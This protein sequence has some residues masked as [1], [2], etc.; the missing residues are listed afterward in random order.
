MKLFRGET[1]L[2]CSMREPIS[3]SAKESRRTPGFWRLL[4]AWLFLFGVFQAH[5]SWPAPEPNEPHYL[6]KAKRFWDRS[7]IED[8]AFLNSRDAHGV[9]FFTC[10]WITQFLSLPAAAWTGRIVCNS[11]LALGW[12]R[13]GRSLELS[14]L[15]TVFSGGAWIALNE[16][17]QMAGEWIVGGFEAK[18]IAYGLMLLGLAQAA[19]GNWR[20]CWPWLG[21]S[22]AF[23]PLVG[24]WSVVACLFAWALV[25]R[26]EQTLVSQLSRLFLGGAASLPGVLPILLLNRGV[27]HDIRELAARVYF[28]RLRHH[29]DI[30]SFPSNMV[31]AMCL[32]LVVWLTLCA[33]SR[34]LNRND[35]QRQRRLQAAVAGSLLIA[36]FGILFTLPSWEQPSRAAWILRYYFYRTA[37][38]YVPLGTAIA[39]AVGMMRTPHCGENK[40]WNYG[41]TALMLVLLTWHMT[42]LRE[43]LIAKI[44]RADKPGKIANFADWVDVC[45]WI[46]LNTD[47]RDRFLTPRLGQSFKWRAER[48]EVVTAKD[49]P[50]DDA[51]LALWHTLQ[52]EVFRNMD[53]CAEANWYQVVGE[54]EGP[55]AVQ[56]AHRTKATHIVTERRYPMNWQPIYQNKSYAV[57]KVP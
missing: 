28:R 44:P 43:R 18:G 5:G 3:D 2:M 29:L 35:W 56:I 11:L 9:F 8:D 37:D 36:V 14:L 50:Q 42:T 16:H 23:H 27:D 7:W 13:L 4:V 19:Q 24:G 20:G 40:R 12:L 52:Q 17:G 30:T 49:V 41:I 39:A 38:V 21:V 33:L 25:G 51:G 55:V 57:Y 54:Y 47:R 26:R 22:S 10:G 32:L 31:F 53:P 34:Y 1:V 46:K 15:S 6:S 45:N 48:A